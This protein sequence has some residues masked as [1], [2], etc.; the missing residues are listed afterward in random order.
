MS[1]HS[2]RIGFT[3]ATLAMV[4]VLGAG[5]SV[6]SKVRNA[7]H[8][9]E[10]NKATIDSF[11]QNLQS[12]QSSPFEVTYTTTGSA[13]ATVLYAVD[14]NSGGLAFHTTQTGA[15]ASNLQLIVNSSG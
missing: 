3:V 6:V 15:N 11:T 2:K 10:G 5:C 1:R 13:P 8:N 7:V 9:V 4:G 14:P 12:G